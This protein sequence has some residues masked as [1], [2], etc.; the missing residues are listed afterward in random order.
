MSRRDR[1]KAPHQLDAGGKRYVMLPHVVMESEAYRHLSLRARAILT[2]ILKRFNFYNNA[3]P[4]PHRRLALSSR[5][6]A[7]E[8]NNQNHAANSRAIAELIDHGF[9]EMTAESVRSSR[10]AREYRITFAWSGRDEAPVKPTNEYRSWRPGPE[11]KGGNKGKL[12]VEDVATET[13]VSV[14]PAA[15]SPKVFVEPVATSRTN[16]PQKTVGRSVAPA[17]TQGP[18]QGKGAGSREPDPPV[19]RPTGPRLSRL[20]VANPCVPDVDEMRDRASAFLATAPRGSQTILSRDAGIPAGT[21]SKFLKRG[22]PLGR[23]AR[24]ALA[25]AIARLEAQ[26]RKGRAA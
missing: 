18:Y 3:H 24:L 23:D 22:G 19:R 5:E 10:L 8:L 20:P 16:F 4:S 1:E 26:A 25:A 7:A 6:I 15:T 13:P 14:D 11:A 17:S 2:L 9:V 12:A 21:F